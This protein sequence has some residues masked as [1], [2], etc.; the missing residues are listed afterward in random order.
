VLPSSIVFA[1]GSAALT[2]A[3]KSKLLNFIAKQKDRKV[4]KITIAGF[5]QKDAKGR[6]ARALAV[7]RGEVLAAF[8]RENG[9]DV[10]FVITDQGLSSYSGMKA[11]NVT[12]NSSW[13]KFTS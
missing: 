4:L 11:R 3:A 13:R 2:K 7:K 10:R 1:E 12:I 5:G 8:F 9:I 6:Y